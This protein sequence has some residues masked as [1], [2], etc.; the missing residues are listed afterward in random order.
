MSLNGPTLAGEMFLLS[1]HPLSTPMPGIER[2][3]SCS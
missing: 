2:M 1:K 3:P